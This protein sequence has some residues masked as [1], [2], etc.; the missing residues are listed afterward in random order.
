MAVPASSRH[1]ARTAPLS[2][3]W[4]P[5][6]SSGCSFHHGVPLP[7]IKFGYGTIWRVGP[8]ENVEIL[9]GGSAG[10]PTD[11]AAIT[12][13]S[14]NASVGSRARPIEGP[15][16]IMAVLENLAV[17]AKGLGTSL[18]G[19]SY[20]IDTRHF[21]SF[22]P[23]NF[24]GYVNGFAFGVVGRDIRF[25]LNLDTKQDI[26]FSLHIL[27]KKRVLWKDSR[28]AFKNSGW[29]RRTGGMAGIR[30]AASVEK[31]IEY[32]KSK[33]GDAVE[34]THH[35]MQ[36]SVKHQNVSIHVSR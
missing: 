19:Y 15:R 25:D 26:D 3:P 18:F 21:H 36:G 20:T 30:T 1:S 7:S 33:W 28:F 8:H 22:K 4:V 14:G 35:K 6:W 29:F 24:T 11:Q 27:L 17:I 16:A 32:L 23:F 5:G 31:D 34:I 13:V 2:A 10:L 9:I 12:S